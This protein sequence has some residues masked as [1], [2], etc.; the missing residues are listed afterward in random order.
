MRLTARSEEGHAYF[1]QCFKEPCLGC[2]CEKENCEFINQVCER[3]AEYEE[4]EE[5]EVIEI[6]DIEDIP[7]TDEEADAAVET[8]KRYCKENECKNCTL[9]KICDR[10]WVEIP[11]TWRRV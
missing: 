10:D 8:L 3:L 5:Q 7:V 2:G 6:L 1:P 4:R 11:R 9:Y